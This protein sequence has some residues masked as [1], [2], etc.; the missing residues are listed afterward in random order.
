MPSFR[1]AYPG[2]TFVWPQHMRSVDFHL[3]T[4]DDS[5]RAT[6]GDLRP[7]ID[8][9][10]MRVVQFADFDALRTM[11]MSLKADVILAERWGQSDREVL[12]EDRQH[13]LAVA[14]LAPTV[15]LTDQS[16]GATVSAAD[17]GVSC[18]LTKP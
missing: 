8:S 3:A 10:G 15:L 14:R 16:W 5:Q 4:G 13:I 6:S 17:L 1:S 18:V 7:A 2:R 12:P 9:A 11:T